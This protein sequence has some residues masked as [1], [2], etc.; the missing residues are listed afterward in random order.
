MSWVVVAAHSRCRTYAVMPLNSNTILVTG[1]AGFIGSHVTERLIEA[2]HHVVNLD[3]LTYAG[4]SDNL[5]AVAGHN[6]YSFVHGDI[7]DS[8]LVRK[9]LADH[10]PA[11]VF[12]I[13]AES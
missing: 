11:I 7:C 1:G 4:N 3:L 12:N 8:R 9:L 6:R 13:A 5:T 2:G 10:R